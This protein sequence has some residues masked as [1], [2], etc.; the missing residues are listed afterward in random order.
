MALYTWDQ[1]PDP[2]PYASWHSSQVREQGF[3]LSGF[4]NERLDQ[5]LSE[6][7]QTGDQERRRVL[8]A[9]FQQIFA[10]E[11]PSVLLFY[12]VYH[13]Y[14]E[15]AVKGIAL[16]VLFEPSSRFANVNEWYIKTRRGSS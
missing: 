12:P 5:V 10:E 16:G 14:V 9:E 2:D 7:R 11:V 15:D 13:Y 6:A 8:Y 3:N 1:G 4:V